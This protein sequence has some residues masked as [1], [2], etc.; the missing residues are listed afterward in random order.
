MSTFYFRFL[1]ALALY[2]LGQR[3]SRTMENFDYLTTEVIS[4]SQIA[5]TM[6][7]LYFILIG[8]LVDKCQQVVTTVDQQRQT[9]F[10][11]LDRFM[12]YAKLQ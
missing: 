8:T 2:M 10:E 4:K 1:I 6:S 7:Y 3:N 5:F 12:T 9:A 11:S